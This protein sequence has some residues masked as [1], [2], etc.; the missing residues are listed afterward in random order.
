MSKA[1]G[2]LGAVRETLCPHAAYPDHDFVEHGGDDATMHRI[3]EADVRQ[4]G[5]EFGLNSGSV[6]FKAT[7]QAAGI[8][9]AAE[10]ARFSRRKR[11][12]GR[13]HIGLST[14]RQPKSLETPALP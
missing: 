13:Q 9:S 14:R 4:A 5:N 7:M 10:K 2:H 12:H 3:S 6:C 11:L 1:D 8:L